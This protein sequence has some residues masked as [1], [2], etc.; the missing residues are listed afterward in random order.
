VAKICSHHCSMVWCQLCSNVKPF[1]VYKHSVNRGHGAGARVLYLSTGSSKIC[2]VSRIRLG[3]NGSNC[4]QGSFPAGTP[5]NGVP[6][7]ILTVGMAFPGTQNQLLVNCTK[8]TQFAPKFAYLRSQIEFF[9]GEPIGKGLLTPH[10]LGTFGARIR[11]S[12]HLLILEPPQFG[13]HTSFLG[14]DL[15]LH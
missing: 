9:S 12:P 15:W 2:Q 5:G 6:K 1:C 8:S 11:S 7:V 14:N 4:T 10:V 13:S 3:L